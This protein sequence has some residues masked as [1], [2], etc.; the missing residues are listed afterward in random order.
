LPLAVT[1]DTLVLPIENNSREKFDSRDGDYNVLPRSFVDANTSE[2]P[3]ASIFKVEDACTLKM[4]AEFFPGT[5]FI[6]AKLQY[7]K[8]G[9]TGQLFSQV[10]FRIPVREEDRDALKQLPLS[11]GKACSLQH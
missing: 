7:R 11:S 4:A 10:S 5:L 8:V 2:E 3:V 1:L 9:W 6:S